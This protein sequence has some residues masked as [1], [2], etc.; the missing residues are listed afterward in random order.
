MIFS[1]SR[2]YCEFADYTALWLAGGL[3]AAVEQPRI[4]LIT[5]VI[6]NTVVDLHGIKKGNDRG[7][8]TNHFYREECGGDA[9]YLI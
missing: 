7:D 5:Y 6:L 1:N 9:P 3:G 4:L 2:F 8:A